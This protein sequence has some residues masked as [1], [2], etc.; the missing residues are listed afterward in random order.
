MIARLLSIR[1]FGI[2]LKGRI[3]AKHPDAA[4]RIYE[5]EIVMVCF[6]Y[7]YTCVLDW[8]LMCLDVRLGELVCES[9]L[10]EAFNGVPLIN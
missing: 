5:L 8:C 9:E 7:S 3:V 10:L 2:S 1:R 6:N 4:S